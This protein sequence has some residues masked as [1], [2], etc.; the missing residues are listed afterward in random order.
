MKINI[1]GS[2]NAFHSNGRAHAAYLIESADAGCILLDCG[3]TTLYRLQQI[4]FD[5]NQLEAIL[6][7]H[8]HGDHFSGL[9][10]LWIQMWVVDHRQSAL[11]I[12]GPRGIKEK[13][14]A[15]MDICYPDF[16]EK[17]RLEFYELEES[18]SF[19][20]LYNHSDFGVMSFPI[21]H[22]PESLGYRLRDQNGV[23]AFCGDSRFDENLFRLTD[24]VDL[25]VIE[26]SIFKQDDPP[27]AHVSLEEI[28]KNLNK[29]NARE[30]VFSHIYDDLA[31]A[32]EEFGLKTAYDGMMLEI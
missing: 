4:R 18:N 27:V 28:K 32:A 6:I 17:C 13:C 14:K 26:L 16:F 24:G 2:G 25:A 15:L 10:F 22:R 5:L 30:I 7:T 19:E 29:I 8:F 3:A 21:E 31:E 11:K 1:L 12:F 20:T 9:P 23:F